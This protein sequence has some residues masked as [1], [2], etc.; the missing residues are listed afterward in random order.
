[1]SSF[2]S[3][4]FSNL[5]RHFVTLLLRYQDVVWIVASE[6]EIDFN[7]STAADRLN[8]RERAPHLQLAV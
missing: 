3:K 5:I 7:L 1:L 4:N 6:E 2:D 8:V